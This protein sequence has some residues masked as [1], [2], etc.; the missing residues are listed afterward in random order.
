MQI[1]RLGQGT[2]MMGERRRRRADEVAALRLGIELGMTLIDTAEMYGD[3]GA[4]EVV[5]EAIAGRRNDVFIVSKVL[6]HNASRQG[7]IQAAEQSLRRLGTEYL[8]LYLLHWPGPYR[9]AET[10]EA[11]ARLVEAGKIRHF[12]VSNLDLHE[13]QASEQVPGG[14]Q[15]Q[16]NQVLYNLERRGI[17][18]TLL[19]WCAERG[20]AVMAYSPL[21]QGRLRQRSAL[22]R[23]AERHGVGPYDVALAWTLR[24]PGVVAIAKSGDPDHIRRNAA[25]PR[26]VLGKE[27]IAELDR[28]YP[29]P[30]RDVPLETL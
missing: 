6:P 17:E 19:P 1:P 9:L 24:L 18:R 13:M 29:P 3:G 25:A 16:A 28:E 2:W 4:E 10:Y 15:V 23:V 11:F 21:E 14:D 5:G 26:L 7:T 20:I 30:D 12:G 22:F 27:E 8:D